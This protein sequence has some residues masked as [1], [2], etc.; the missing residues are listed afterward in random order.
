MFNCKRKKS[1]DSIMRIG[2]VRCGLDTAIANT[3][4][5]GLRNGGWTE[6]GS[7]PGGIG[8]RCVRFYAYD[9]DCAARQQLFLRAVTI[10][11][12]SFLHKR[13]R[14]AS[15]FFDGYRELQFIVQLRR[16]EIIDGGAFDNEDDALIGVQRMLSDAQGAQPF[17]AG[18]LKK[19]Q[20]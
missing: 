7:A 20:V 17:G 5:N 3:V 4:Q 18:T 8:V 12:P 6:I 19:F 10:Q 13:D 11:T 1:P 2:A 14:C 16:S 15:Q 9:I